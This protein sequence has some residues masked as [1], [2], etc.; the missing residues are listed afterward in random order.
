MDCAGITGY[1]SQLPVINGDG[2]VNSFA[3]MDSVRSGRLQEWLAREKVPY[4]ATYTAVQPDSLHGRYIDWAVT[5]LGGMDFIF[6]SSQV[7]LRAP[8][9]IDNIRFHST[10]EWL[11]FAFD[12]KS[13]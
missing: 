10:G 1:F 2:L 7:L 12:N 3:Y 8:F 6:D 13:K 4:Y 5:G 11:V 9:R